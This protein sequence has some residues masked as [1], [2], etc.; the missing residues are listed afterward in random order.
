MLITFAVAANARIVRPLVPSPVKIKPGKIR[1]RPDFDGIATI[2]WSSG[3]EVPPYSIVKL[4]VDALVLLA[5]SHTS[6]VTPLLACV[7]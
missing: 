7:V 6:S 2:I 5:Q 1:L 3:F 4:T